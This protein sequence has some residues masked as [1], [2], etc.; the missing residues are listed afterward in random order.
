MSGA[1]REVEA[2]GDGAV[3][4]LRDPDGDPRALLEALRDVPGVIDAVVTEAHALVTFD[5]A[6]P[7]GDPPWAVEERLSHR[8]GAGKAIRE[9]VVHA[10]YDGPDLDE[11]AS[12]SGLSQGEVVRAHVAGE[13]VVRV[14]GFLPGFAYLGPLP[15]ALVLPRRATPRPRVEAGAIAIAA[16]Y[17]GVYPFASPGG[18]HLIGK[19]LDFTPFDAEHGARFALGDRVR[20]EEAR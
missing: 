15:P 2:M 6:H 13:Y 17:T 12:R 16:A 10:R 20:F 5:P 9:H 8:S 14:I 4:W 7:P 11:V 19:A 1:P 3:R 18:W